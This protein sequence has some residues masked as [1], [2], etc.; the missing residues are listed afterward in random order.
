MNVYRGRIVLLGQDRAGK[1]SLK[2]N[3]LGLPFD[4]EEQ[5]TKGIEVQA[6]TCEIKVEQVENWHAT[7]ED[8]P[9]LLEYS[10]DISRIVAEKLC[11]GTTE[12]ER[13]HSTAATE[14]TAMT[15]EEHFKEEGGELI[16]RNDPNKHQ[17]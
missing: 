15:K 14:A 10:K 8:K 2:K 4:P 5:S 9:F 11:D 16:D 1:T 6:S 17:V 12:L 7:H 13:E 3:L